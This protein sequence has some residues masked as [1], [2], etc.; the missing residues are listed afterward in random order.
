MG[1]LPEL[2]SKD[3]RGGTE[4]MKMPDGWVFI[5]KIKG[6]TTIEMTQE[7]LIMC[8]NCIFQGT[9]ECKWRSDEIPKDDDWCSGGRVF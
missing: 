3:G 2:R 8:K 5:A 4:M 9:D 6:R 1:V 7:E